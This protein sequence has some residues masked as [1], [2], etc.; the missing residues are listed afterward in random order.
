[1]CELGMCELGMC[2]LGMCELGSCELGSDSFY[3]FVLPLCYVS[4][5]TLITQMQLNKRNHITASALIQTINV[6]QL[7]WKCEHIKWAVAWG[8]CDLGM[9]EL[10]IY[11]LGMCD[12]GMCELC[13]WNYECVNYKCVD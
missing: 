13:A 2:E 4:S 12:L 9:C 8:M 6:M 5:S 1:M 3:A 7:H 11:E 10:G